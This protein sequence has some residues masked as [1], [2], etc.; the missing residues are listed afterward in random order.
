MMTRK[1]RRRRMIR[2]RNRRSKYEN[3]PVSTHLL[4]L[5]L[6]T[7]VSLEQRGTDSPFD[8]KERSQV[9]QSTILVR[10]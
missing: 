2:W 1:K 5:L 10:E 3:I 7:A 8:Q 4:Q 6:S 9:G